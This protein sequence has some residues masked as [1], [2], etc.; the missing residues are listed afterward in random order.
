MDAGVAFLIT[1]V[2]QEA[3]E[4]G[5]GTAVRASGFDATAA[6]KTGTTN[7]A[8]DA[9]FVGYTPSLVAAVWMGFDEPRPIMALATG[10]RLAAPVWG[11]MMVRAR[12][13]TPALAAWTTPS[14]VVQ[15]W[16]DPETGVPL[17]EGCRPFSGRAFRELFLRGS[18]PDL[19]CPDR[20]EVIQADL[21]PAPSDEDE[22]RGF[23]LWPDDV[24]AGSE[25]APPPEY[26]EAERSRRRA[27]EWRRAR[28]ER[29]ER[30]RGEWE[31]E[32][33][34]RRKEVEKAWRKARK[35]VERRRRGWEKE[36]EKRRREWEKREVR[37]R[38]R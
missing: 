16:V 12:S 2:L 31:K 10:G 17:A 14:K 4:H 6:G 21:Y 22:A 26:E 35:E 18:M 37:R 38:E 29:D 36:Q 27:E 32:D 13:G 24:R 33:K 34:E 3:L 25:P 9:W 11:R 1:N 15:A 20:G 19:A 30:R 28:R 7:D 8:T 23:D 5:T